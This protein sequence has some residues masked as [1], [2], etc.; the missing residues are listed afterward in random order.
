MKKIA[1]FETIAPTGHI[2]IDM[3]NPIFNVE[4]L[5][6]DD[7]TALLEQVYAELLP[8][9]RIFE[10]ITLKNFDHLE[11]ELLK[12]LTMPY[13]FG[14]EIVIDTPKKHFNMTYHNDHPRKYYRYT[15]KDLDLS[16]PIPK[17]LANFKFE[18]NGTPTTYLQAI[19]H[20][21]STRY[22]PNEIWKALDQYSQQRI[23]EMKAHNMG[24][25]DIAEQWYKQLIKDTQKT[26]IK[27]YSPN[28]KSYFEA[29][30]ELN[31]TKDCQ[32]YRL[33]DNEQPLTQEQLDY[34]HKYAPIYGLEIPTLKYRYATR[35]TEHGWTCEPEICHCGMSTNDYN[36]TTF[37]GRNR[38]KYNTMPNIKSNVEYDARNNNYKINSKITTHEYNHEI[39]NPQ[40]QPM[41][42][43][44]R[45]GLRIREI[46]NDKMLLD[47]YNN[48]KWIIENM[49]DD[50]LMPNWKR[51]PHCGKLY[52][53]HDGC[54]CGAIPPIEFINADNL[55]YSNASTYED[56]ES[57]RETYNEMNNIDLEFD[58]LN[59]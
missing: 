56:Y 6:L 28:K 30:A 27:V 36:Q 47:T 49:G 29:M 33:Q 39:D 12:R 54:E 2:V 1:V 22:L 18:F 23:N 35:K 13:I 51:C 52:N 11:S 59:E 20:L 17:S 34:L 50:A 43:N 21:T 15:F 37:D 26:P 5:T 48:L 32:Q 58:G 44:I 4:G 25:Y 38:N 7:T 14:S 8:T 57:T 31:F 46:D 55:F 41:P 9:G 19:S 10:R 45:D 16:A 53:I 24:G 40:R 3:H 42:H